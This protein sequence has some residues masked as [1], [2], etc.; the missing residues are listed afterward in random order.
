MKQADCNGTAVSWQIYRKEIERQLR[1]FDITDPE[2]K[3]DGMLI[4]GGQDLVDVN[5]ALPDPT[6]EEGDDTFKVLVRK[7]NHHFMPKKN[8]DFA[9]FKLS[10][11][12]QQTSERLADYYS[13]VRETEMK[14]DYGTHEDNAI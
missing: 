13:K 3:R 12:K 9:R 14:C 8:K 4:Y 7:I 6:N 2:T 1:F 10:G 11:L 5:D